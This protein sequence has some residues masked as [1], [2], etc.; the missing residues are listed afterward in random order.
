MPKQKY[1]L[2]NC[3][4]C[5]KC[6]NCKDCPNCKKYILNGGKLIGQGSYGCVFRP[7]I[8]CK[9]SNKRIPG[10]VSKFLNKNEA[11][12]EI[13][14][15]TILEVVKCFE[16]TLKRKVLFKFKDRRIGD[17]PKSLADIEKSKKFLCLS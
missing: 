13:K 10:K 7:M 3:Y 14:E 16:K 6:K 1:N 11:N 17:I 5:K 12:D 9:G 4:F 2:K 8:P 15:N